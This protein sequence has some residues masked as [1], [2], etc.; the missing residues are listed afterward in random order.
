M[1]IRRFGGLE[2]W[3]PESSEA[4]FL[5]SVASEETAQGRFGHA[6][7]GFQKAPDAPCTLRRR[8]PMSSDVS[9]TGFGSVLLE[10][11]AVHKGM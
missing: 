1:E 4:M 2:V 5:C 11:L 3:R 10:S 8:L 9:N 6:Q 7:M